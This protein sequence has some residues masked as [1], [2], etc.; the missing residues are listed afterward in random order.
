[1]TLQRW[2]GYCL[3]VYQLIADMRL[4]LEKLYFSGDSIKMRVSE[5]ALG[6]CH[7]FI[8]LKAKP[9]VDVGFDIMV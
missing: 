8:F 4:A 2:V 7:R 9:I 1:M 5:E 6:L 3:S